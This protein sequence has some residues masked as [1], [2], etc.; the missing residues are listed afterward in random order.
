[1]PTKAQVEAVFGHGYRV[2]E[3][4]LPITTPHVIVSENARLMLALYADGGDKRRGRECRSWLSPPVYER[5][6]WRVWQQMWA[7]A[8]GW[9]FNTKHTPIHRW[10][11]ATP[12]CT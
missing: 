9:F 7:D 3:K 1:M 11:G 6:N 12:H 8:P 2:V 5:C 10:D 4:M